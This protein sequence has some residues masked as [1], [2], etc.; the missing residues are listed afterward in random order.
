MRNGR[1]KTF[2]SKTGKKK[3]KKKPSRKSGETE[4]NLAEKK[5]YFSC[6]KNGQGGNT[7]RR[8]TVERDG[9]G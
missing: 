3:T 5:R 2:S 1:E 8:E 9:D 7:Q 4:K 6:L